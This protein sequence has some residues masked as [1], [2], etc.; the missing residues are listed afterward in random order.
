MYLSRA[1]CKR[2][3]FGLSLALC[4]FLT[5]PAWGQETAE[6]MVGQ[7]P[8]LWASWQSATGALERE[9]LD[10]AASRLDEVLAL[11]PTE[12]R[13]ALMADRTGSLRLEGWA[14][15]ADAPE[16][17]R[18][19]TE[20][21]AA[22][23]KQRALA[24][25]GWHFAAIGRFSYADAN[26]KALLDANPDPLALLELSRYNPNRQ[27]I[28]TK[29]LANTDIGPSAKRF[30]ELLDKGEEMLRTDPYEIVSNIAKLDGTSRAV[31]HAT[32]R[33]KASGEHAVPHL[34][35]ALQ[36]SGRRPLH[37]AIIQALPQIGRPAVSPLC[38]ALGMDDNTTKQVLIKALGEIGYPQALPYLAKLAA[39]SKA[40]AEVASAAREAMTA[41]GQAS[42]DV[43][44]LFCK[45][46]GDYYDNV[47][48]LRADSRFD[49][50]NVWY[51]REGQLRMIA[52]PT[53]IYNDVMAMRC[54]EEALQANTD[55]REAIALWLAANFRREAKLGLDVESDQYDPLVNKDGTRPEGFPR[56]VY[57]AQAAGPQYNQ[58]VLDRAVKGREP[59]VA[60]GAIA[61]LRSTAGGPSLIGA[62]ALNQ[63]LVQSLAFPNRQV[64]LKA[65]LALGSALPTQPFAGDKDVVP[66]L[67]E[68]LTQAGRQAALVVD[69]DSDTANKFQAILRAAGFECAVGANLYNALENGKKANLSSFD[70]ILLSTDIAE[71]DVLKAVGDLRQRFQTAA[72]P[73]LVTTKSGAMNTAREAAR[74]AGG[75]EILPVEVLESGDPAEMQAQTSDRID[76]AARALGMSPLGKD[77]SLELALQ[78]ADVLHRIGESNSKVLDFS[79]AVSAMVA[80]LS[81][82]SEPLRTKCALVLALANDRSAQTAIAE[83]ALD[84]QR[85][86]VERAAAF[87]ALAESARRNGNLLGTGEL[88]EKIIAAARNGQNPTLQAAASEALGALN[89]P[90][91]KASEIIRAQYR[92]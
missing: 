37:A 41:L 57:F 1:A 62:A 30:L 54:C 56:A 61:A 51:L 78:A 45:L 31:Y 89:L 66:V 84:E 40:T 9:Q 22:G 72:T 18:S 53:A 64:R 58:M 42:G 38:I 21:I 67:A 46:A 14:Q 11:K 47:D 50:A 52:V 77:L 80:A 48:S 60:L 16:V 13:L 76:R 8:D 25:D 86:E 88:V 4:V 36:D 71:P 15:S 92:G 2:W 24:E 23:R 19:V 43:S 35:Q 55:N 17:V 69:S 3:A 83:A 70:V 49:T 27:L 39:D 81:S 7:P 73:I 87:S 59:A 6:D 85:N 68:A 74:L 34:I 20:M 32:N 10:E 65:A 90:G 5:G 91:N 12:L 82:R 33:L 44:A 29:L 26:F 75:V 28:L 79:K 63:P